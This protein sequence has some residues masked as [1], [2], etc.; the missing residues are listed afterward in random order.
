MGY[1][2]TFFKDKTGSG[3]LTISKL[4]RIITLLVFLLLAGVFVYNV[5][6]HNSLLINSFFLILIFLACFY[7]EY[8]YFST[9][10]Q[11]ITFAFGIAYWIKKV[12]IPIENINAIKFVKILKKQGKTKTEKVVSAQLILTA[13]EKDAVIDSIVGKKISTLE[14]TAIEIAQIL[15]VELE[16]ISI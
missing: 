8:W 12:E 1:S 14:K 6:N 5:I 3:I 9:K 10:D 4:Q 16:Y 7:R 2:L 11:S 13:T 15:G